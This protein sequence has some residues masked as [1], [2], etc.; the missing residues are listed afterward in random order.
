M[1]QTQETVKQLDGICA[2]DGEYS[3]AEDEAIVHVKEEITEINETQETLKQLENMCE[4]DEER[5]PQV[6]EGRGLYLFVRR[7]IY[8]KLFSIARLLS[9]VRKLLPWVRGQGR[10]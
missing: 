4:N 2:N 1:D 10:R 7:I 5:S 9:C 6:G 8:G 3:P